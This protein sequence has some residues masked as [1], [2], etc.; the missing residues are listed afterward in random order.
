MS[1]NGV[2]HRHKLN[3]THRGLCSIH[4]SQ[5]NL[6]VFAVVTAADSLGVNVIKPSCLRCQR[7]SSQSAPEFLFL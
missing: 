1:C 5:N 7:Q 3:L 6:D 2:A 4:G